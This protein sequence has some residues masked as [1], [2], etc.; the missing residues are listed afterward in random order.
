MTQD[1]YRAEVDDHTVAIPVVAQAPQ[2]A[3]DN[4][5]MRAYYAGVSPEDL[6][7]R[8]SESLTE[9]ANKHRR[10][11]QTRAPGQ[12]LIHVDR[13][14][15]RAV[16]YVVTEDV[17]YVVSTINTQIAQKWGG[18]R[19]VVHPILQVTRD[20]DGG[21]GSV[22]EVP[23][24]AAHSSGDTQTIPAVGGLGERAAME[25]WVQVVLTRELD[26]DA[27]AQLISELHPV[28]ADVAVIARDHEA[29]RD[30]VQNLVVSLD[31]LARRDEQDGL[32]LGDVAAAQDFLRWMLDGNFVLMGIKEY[33]LNGP[34]EQ[35]YLES[36]PDTGLGLL[37]ESG[38]NPYRRQ[39]TQQAQEHAKDAETLFVTKA[40]T[41]SELHRSEFLDYIG[42]RRFNANGQVDGEHLIIGLFARKAYAT[43][44][45]ETPWVKDKIQAVATQFGFREDSHSAR[46][47]L[48][49]MEE[50]PR[51]EL[52]HMS[53]DELAEVARGVLGLDERRVTKIFVR[54]DLFG[55]FVSAVVYLPRD[56]YNTS[57]RQRISDVL[58]DT[59]G[60]T[61]VDFQVRLSSSALARVFF[62]LRLPGDT[63]PP[64]N[65]AEL[66]SR[67]RSAVRSWPDALVRAIGAE[68]SGEQ[69]REYAYNWAEAFPPAYRADY[70]I[71][72]AVADLQRC[73]MLSGQEPEQ[74]AEVRVAT[75]SDG[76]QDQVRLNVY[77]TRRLTLTEMLPMEQ[78]LGMTVVD[79]KPYEITPADGREFQLYDFGVELPAGVDPVGPP[80]ARTED[81]IEEVLCA[82]LS[83]QSESDALDRLVLVERLHWRTIAVLRAYV[84]YL[85]Q[86][87]VPHSFEFMAATLLSYPGVTR[88]VVELFETSFDPDRFLTHDGA[89]DDQAR[90]Q[91]R[92]EA[93]E[94]V[95]AALEEVPTLDAD[96][97]LRTLVE[98]VDATLRT[99][100]YQTDRPT[101][102]LKLNPQR[103]SAAPLPRPQFEIW[104]WSPRV[105]GTHLRFGPV[106]RGGLRWSDRREDFRTEVL[107]LVKAQMVKNAVIIPNGAKG[108]FFPK[109]LPDPSVD[110]GAWAAEGEEA[111]KEFVGAL[112]D[113]T[114]NLE[115]AAG[116]SGNDDAGGAGDRTVPPARTVRK[117]G[118]DSYL[119][120]AADK[121]TARFSDTANAISLDRG[122]WL[123]DAFASGGS[124]GYDHKAM[125]ITAR[126]AWES[127]KRHFFELGHDTQT[128]DFTVVGVGDMSGDVF[129]NGMLLSEHIK[130]V[131]AFDHRDIFLDPNPD[132]AV[133][134]AERERLFGLARSSWQDYDSAKISAGGGVFSRE[135]K[136]V[137]VSE[138]VRALLELPESTTQ[139]SPIEL[140]RAILQAPADLFYN[141]GIGTYIKG[142]T[143]THA[144][145]GDKANDAIRVDGQELRVKVVGEGGNLGVTQLGRIETARNGVL[146]NTD[147]IDNSGGVESSD[148]EVNIKILVDR[149]VTAGRLKAEARA[150][151]IESMTDDVADLVLRTNV[152]QNVT[153]TVDRW[154]AA[155]YMVTYE[156]LMD[157]LEEAADLDRAIEFLPDT[158]PMEERIAAGETMTS[159]E[160]SV[161][162]AYAKIQL[163][164]ALI[165]SDLA[166]DPWTSTVVETYFPAP[167]LE[168]FGEDLQTHPLRRQI[169]CTMVAN[170]MINVGGAS[171][172]FR[173]MD[174]T[175]CTPADL[176]KAFLAT[177]AIFDVD[178]YLDQVAHLSAEIPTELWVRM[179]QDQRRLVDRSVRW[180]IS[181]DET[182]HPITDVIQRYEPIAALRSSDTVL[183]G[184]ESA[185]RDD[186][187]LAIA[188][189]QGVPEGLAREW[190]WMLDS[191]P[192]LDVVRLGTQAGEDL[193]VVGRVYFLL[194]DRF[195]IESLLKRIGELPQNTR[196]EALARISMR[197]DV[198]STLVAMAAQA[199][200]VDGQSPED[201]VEAWESV[202]EAQLARLRSTLEDIA[203][204]NTGDPAGDLAALSV[205]LRTM[206][207]AVQD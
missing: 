35:L 85:L 39:L 207:A 44:A 66:E 156:R 158:E 142:S 150:E 86:L 72:E 113:V 118:D 81:L 70:E 18:A 173:A 4:A 146:I 30:S 99:N 88:A 61:D 42:I 94:A 119:V 122:F 104:V 63:P 75:V 19:L 180:L 107:G 192:L 199:L 181:R 80:E 205:A 73:E 188:T 195:N 138:E 25:S 79:Q 151:F 62:R 185:S 21:L 28:L 157:W 187:L 140:M 194:Y 160:L 23:N 179:L 125:G 135:A 33:D 12:T 38:R 97:F 166:E 76:E 174:E 58:T 116:S 153:L 77:L 193:E 200:R 34:D 130:L 20:E 82:V 102:A 53:V 47:L 91:A 161:L 22:M 127:V 109:Q 147:A 141:G 56:R 206:R 106:S 196:W 93:R 149:M 123:G 89:A 159:P 155:D 204:S 95:S 6:A 129:G 203:A 165:D 176:A 108:C 8:P 87:G 13:E 132:P 197:E 164:E 163:S 45:R 114:D 178:P 202:S 144:E 59:Y 111:Y 1:K 32:H 137:P 182:S 7:S 40:N 131:A 65:M 186:E 105:E 51:D 27:A 74:A 190:S 143:E 120:V 162:M 175:S 55:R 84:K 171:F 184:H 103:I 148:R 15:Q 68:F 100:A 168:R 170:H 92:K 48:S 31:G 96:R 49:I 134:Y 36:R 26:E 110:R 191:Y 50:Y 139:L 2:F 121:G 52:L 154:K 5:W 172:A 10:V 11:A 29:M 14:A 124:V 128:Q 69:A 54:P 189:R 152:A 101:I 98:V 167:V 177:V 64:V 90:Q 46:D 201:R 37:S 198:Y 112:L 43:P 117:D 133:S 126:G 78:N 145:V 136:S 169:L 83:G 67:V 60:A 3:G 16:L 9:R 24:F 41:R 17:P 115:I 57:V 71:D 183:L